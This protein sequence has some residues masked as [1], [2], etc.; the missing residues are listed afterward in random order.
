MDH[1][2]GK[3]C[4]RAG[5]VSQGLCLVLTTRPKGRR[6]LIIVP[7]QPEQAMKMG[8]TTSLVLCIMYCYRLT[9]IIG[10]YLKF[11]PVEVRFH[12]VLDTIMLQERIGWTE[13]SLFLQ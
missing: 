10:Y 7:S 9:I 12:T 13:R 2:V 5:D 8:G 11:Y 3:R 1:S 4:D 6:L